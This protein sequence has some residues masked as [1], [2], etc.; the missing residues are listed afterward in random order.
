VWNW[1]LPWNKQP[2]GSEGHQGEEVDCLIFAG[3]TALSK[4]EN[5]QF[6][7]QRRRGS[8]SE[9]CRIY[10]PTWKITASAHRLDN[11]QC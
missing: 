7:D 2:I 6:H 11:L 10:Q 1:V 9:K 8:W 4:L 5:K 3:E